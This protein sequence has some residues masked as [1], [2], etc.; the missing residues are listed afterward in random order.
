MEEIKKVTTKSKEKRTSKQ[1]IELK[2]AQF[3]S[4]VGRP[5]AYY[6]IIAQAIGSVKAGVFICQLLYW[7]GKGKEGEWIYKSR[8]EM[9]EET[10]LSRNE[11]DT[12]REVLRKLNIIEEKLKGRAPATT[13]YK[14]NFSQ[15]NKVVNNYLMG[16]EEA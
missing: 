1:K 5:V 4:T 13:H 14:I 15:L 6:P 12:A 2:V 8:I 16:K 7:Q 9:T 3:I 11:Q 10:G